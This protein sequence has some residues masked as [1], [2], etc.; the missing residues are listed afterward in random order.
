MK[1]KS[2]DN[3]KR[4]QIEMTQKGDSQNVYIDS[5]SMKINKEIFSFLSVVCFDLF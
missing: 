3:N 5:K 2:T 4:I 1:T